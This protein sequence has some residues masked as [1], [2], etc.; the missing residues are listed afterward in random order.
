[1]RQKSRYFQ[2]LYRQY[3]RTPLHAGG[4][5]ELYLRMVENAEFFS[6]WAIVYQLGDSSYQ[7]DALENMKETVFDECKPSDI[8]MNIL[9]LFEVVT[10]SAEQEEFLQKYLHRFS[11]KDDLLFVMAMSHGGAV[12]DNAESK[13]MDF[14]SSH[15][16]LYRGVVQKHDRLVKRMESS[17]F[18][19]PSV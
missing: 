10:D 3:K 4:R 15:G 9:E 12:H 8:Q 11:E 17:T 6:E 19:L 7:Y 2:S 18:L 16:R 1:M 13:A 5:H 14:Y